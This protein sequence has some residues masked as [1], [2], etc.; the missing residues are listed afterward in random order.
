MI[1]KDFKVHL[2]HDP[3]INGTKLYIF[4]DLDDGR[5]EYFKPTLIESTI[6]E[7]GLILEPTMQ[8]SHRLGDRFLQELSDALVRVGF[9]P[10][11]I[12]V[13]EGE[14]AAMRYHL[15]DM[16]KLVFKDKV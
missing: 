4:R 9:K 7:A 8:F 11:A 1:T 3:H 14:V 13:K 10:D 15:E 16:R 12:T 5:V 6:Q 2:E